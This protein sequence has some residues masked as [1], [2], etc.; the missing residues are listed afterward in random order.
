M[1]CSVITYQK[2]V[3]CKLMVALHGRTNSFL[4]RGRGFGARTPFWSAKYVGRSPCRMY[5]LASAV[6]IHNN[7]EKTSEDI[8]QTILSL[9]KGA[10]IQK[11]VGKN[12]E[13]RGMSSTQEYKIH[14]QTNTTPSTRFPNRA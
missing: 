10:E 9:E 14:T 6:H 3:H 7:H 4:H 5:G 12:S 13:Q 1:A 2:N 11:Q 8:K